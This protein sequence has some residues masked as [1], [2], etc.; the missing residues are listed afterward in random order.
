MTFTGRYRKF[1]LHEER[2]VKEA[3]R[4]KD[5]TYTVPVEEGQ[6]LYRAGYDS[7]VG[8]LLLTCDD[9]G[10][11]D[12]TFEELKEEPSQ[13]AFLDEAKRWLDMY[14]TGKIPDFTPTLNIKGSDFQCMIWDYLLKNIPYGSTMTYGDMAKEL[15]CKSAQAVGRAVGKNHIA[16]IIPCHRVVGFNKRLTGYSGGIDRKEALLLIEKINLPA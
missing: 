2:P 6:V 1:I 12:L 5:S 10:I 13:H 7:P 16:I 15:N 9:K 8:K 3:V 11:T 14:F 4:D